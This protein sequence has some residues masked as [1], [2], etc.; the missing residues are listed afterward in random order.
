[1]PIGRIVLTLAVLAGA[2]VGY[3]LYDPAAMLVLG[4]T[5]GSQ[6]S[7]S[8]G[9]FLSAYWTMR[10]FHGTNMLISVGV[11]VGLLVI[12]V[13]YIVKLA[14]DNATTA[15]LGALLIVFGMATPAHAYWSQTNVTEAYGILPN[16]S[17]F[18]IPGV[19]DNKTDQAR[20]ESEDYLKANKVNAKF[21]IIPHTKLTGSSYMTWDYYIPAGRL[22]VVDRAP[23]FHEWTGKGRGTHGDF[24]ESFHCHSKDNVEVS[25]EMSLASSVTEE[26]A[27]KFLFYF[28]VK[29]PP[30]DASKPEV[31]FTSVFEGRSLADVM[32]T[33]GRGEIQ[34]RV[35]RHVLEHTVEDL[36][37]NGN[38]ILTQIQDEAKQFFTDFGITVEY[39]GWAGGFH[40]PEEVQHAIN[41]RFAAEHVRPVVPVLQAKAWIDAISGWDHHLPTTLGFFG[42]L[43]DVVKQMSPELSQLV[44]PPAPVT[45]PAPKPPAH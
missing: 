8:D 27:A 39:I 41:T 40:Y 14:K 17:A 32:S 44:A 26:N 18:W 7:A 5:A 33:W 3:S 42:G 43:S 1:M 4:K 10:F 23:Y 24:D 38:Q 15:G 35:C 11:L 22:I 34:S 6:L 16:H 2:Y 12:W 37:V 20:T 29:A 31:I 9:G 13:P 19:G 45:A 21:F 25:T 28:G 30:G 36:A